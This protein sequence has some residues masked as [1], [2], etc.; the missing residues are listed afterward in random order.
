MVSTC[1][2]LALR[3]SAT[4]FQAASKRS[5]ASPA[6][7]T[8][9]SS[10]LAKRPARRAHLALEVV[11][12]LLYRPELVGEA[13]AADAPPAVFIKHVSVGQPVGQ[14]RMQLDLEHAAGQEHLLVQQQHMA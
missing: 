5:S 14:V 6:G 8:R 4:R 7:P 13:A 11:A 1:S 10:V 12:Q 3:P 2:T 9:S